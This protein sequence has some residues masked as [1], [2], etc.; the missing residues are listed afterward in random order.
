MCTP[1]M[2]VNLFEGYIGVME[3]VW[4]EDGVEGP[5]LGEERTHIPSSGTESELLPSSEEANRTC[6]GMIPMGD[7]EDE[8]DE[9]N[10]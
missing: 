5:M 3:L 8:E 1:K 7:E 10:Y 9:E 6:G 4:T 2:A